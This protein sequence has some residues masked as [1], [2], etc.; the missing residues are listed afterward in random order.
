M[1]CPYPHPVLCPY[2]SPIP[3]RERVDQHTREEGGKHEAWCW[4]E[5]EEKREADETGLRVRER[6][7]SWRTTK[8]FKVTSAKCK[9]SFSSMM[10]Y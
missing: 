9:I 4:M 10:A 6:M 5:K 3:A 1:Q 7:A 2:R 8:I